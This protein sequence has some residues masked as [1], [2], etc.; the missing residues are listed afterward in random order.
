MN[1][2]RRIEAFLE[3]KS[4]E[5]GASQNTLSAY[6]RDLADFHEFL[7]DQ[8]QDL[9][10]VDMAG[11]E[12]YLVDLVNRDLSRATRAPIIGDQTILSLL[13][14]RKLAR[15]SSSVANHWSRTGKITAQNHDGD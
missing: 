7:I 2:L 13:P 12:T 14:R 8:K 4:A 3:A 15:G 11:V 5:T 10:Q 6:A 1:D 9:M